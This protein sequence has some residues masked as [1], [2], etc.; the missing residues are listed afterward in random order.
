MDGSIYKKRPE[1][2]RK[3]KSAENLNDYSA[4]LN[5]IY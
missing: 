4:L 5:I 2:A 1:M 3:A